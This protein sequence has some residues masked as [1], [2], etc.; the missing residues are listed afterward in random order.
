MNNYSL[1][2]V[3]LQLSDYETPF[4]DFSIGEDA[5]QETVH[6]YT[7]RYLTSFESPFSATYESFLNE[8]QSVSPL[9]GEY[10]DL[11]HEL[12][13]DEFVDSLYELSRELEDSWSNKISNEAAMGDRFVPY[14]T[15]QAEEYFAPVAFEAEQ[16]IEKASQHFSGNNL[17]DHSEAEVERYFNELQFENSGYT[18]AQEQFLGSIIKKVK[19]VVKKGISLAKKGVAAVGKLMPIGLILKKLKALIKPLLNKVLRFAINKLPKN[20]QPHAHDLAKKFLKIN[21]APK[22]RATSSNTSESKGA[23]I[24]T[25]ADTGNTAPVSDTNQDTAP[26]NTNQDA[27][28]SGTGTEAVESPTTGNLDSVQS[29][30]DNYITNLLFSSD[31]YGTGELVMEYGSSNDNLQRELSFETSGINLPS[32]ETAREQFIN[33]LKNLQPGESPAPAIEKFLPA[34][35]LALQPVIKIALSIIGRQKVINFLAGLLSKL[36]AKYVPENVAKPLA[37]SIIDLGM[38]AIGFETYE[39]NKSDLAYEAI[40]NTIQETVQNMG[41]LSESVLNDQEL[42]M[43]E[44]LEAF[45]KA[46]GDNFPSQMIKEDKRPTSEP[47]SWVLMPRNGPKHL[48]KKYTRVYDKVIDNRIATTLTTFRGVTLADF[49]KDKLGLDPHQPVNARIHIYQGIPG[50]KL[51][52]INRYENVPGLG[53][54]VPKGYVQFHPLTVLAASLLLGEPKLGRNFSSKYTTRRYE[55]AVGQRFYYLEIQGAKLKSVPVALTSH[56][57]NIPGEISQ[58]L[59]PA[60]PNSS[61]IQGVMNFVKSEIRFNLYFSEEVSKSVVEQLKKGSYGGPLYT[62]Y[63]TI[64]SA[65]HEVLIRNIGSKIKL[66]HE[67]MPEMFLEKSEDLEEQNIGLIGRVIGGSIGKEV[68]KG[69]MLKLVTYLAKKAYH[70]VINYLKGKSGEFISAQTAPQDGVTIKIIWFNLPVMKQISAIVSAYKGRITAGHIAGLVLPSLPLP[71]IK[72]LP[73]KRFD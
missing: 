33:E 35:I 62:M 1:N 42:L 55:T 41:A 72:V 67:E 53:E 10:V 44:T 38:S 24:A 13:D 8:Q 43:A 57:Q 25:P 46:A 54:S 7:D 2:E 60:T 19:S 11:L 14:A 29:E 31:E 37:A 63:Y 47:G 22:T 6:T 39:M 16:M 70:A 56:K 28:T 30:F 23:T 15:Q 69:I 3:E 52:L 12:S 59:V 21:T 68:I 64:Y 71:E 66:V 58:E 73:G 5:A 34:A 9:A 20:L 40:A 4:A 49:L 65:L 61:D 27:T 26:A 36:V 18:P 32:I 45:E 51:Y 48:Y 17:A 50:T